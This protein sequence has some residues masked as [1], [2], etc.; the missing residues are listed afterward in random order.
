MKMLFLVFLVI[1]VYFVVFMIVVFKS[2]GLEFK[3]KRFFNSFEEFGSIS[4]YFYMK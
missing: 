3:V 1:C 2:C 4:L